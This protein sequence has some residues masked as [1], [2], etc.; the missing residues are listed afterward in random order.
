MA[1]AAQV[2]RQSQIQAGVVNAAKAE[3]LAFWR[4]LDLSDPERARDALVEFM[5]ALVRKYGNAAGA[6]AADFY[7][8]LRADAVTRRA[9]RAIVADADDVAVTEA[10]RRLA[11]SLFDGNVEAMLDGLGAVVDKHVKQVGR[12]TITRSSYADP[13]ARGWAREIRGDTCDFCIMLA[14]RGGVYTRETATFRTHHHCD[15]VAVPE[16][17]Q[18]APEVTA[19]QYAAAEASA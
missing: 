15:C 14:S 9:F 13:D 4:A 16:W 5:P 12:N 10:T 17:D 2:T 19:A 18:S 3:L 8:D 7:D 11:G 6:A 1:T